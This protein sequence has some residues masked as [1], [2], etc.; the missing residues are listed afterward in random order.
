MNPAPAKLLFQ[1][2]TQQGTLA[3]NVIYNC[4]SHMYCPPGLRIDWLISQTIL[5]VKISPSSQFL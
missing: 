3:G 4:N 1:A 5:R 2:V